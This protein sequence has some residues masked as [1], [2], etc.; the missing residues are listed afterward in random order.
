M[1][2][3][4]Y[5]EDMSEEPKAVIEIEPI[6]ES[7]G[8]M[9]KTRDQIKKLVEVPLLSACEELYDKNIRTVSTSANKKDIE[10]GR[11]GYIIIDFGSLSE[12]NRKIA[13]QLGELSHEDNT[14]QILIE[15]PLAKNTT[16]DEI[17][18][19]AES[20]AHKFEKQLMTWAPTYTL[21]DLREIYCD[22][23]AQVEDFI[24]GYYY[25]PKEKLFY[26]SEEHFKKTNEK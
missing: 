23:E 4:S 7:R 25:N 1:G 19:F 15:I 21:Q 17:K 18:K 3:L 20:I 14:G 13:R 16:A 6:Q 9:V 11:P 24:D 2:E 10:S 12:E 22:N 8:S 5:S 26:L